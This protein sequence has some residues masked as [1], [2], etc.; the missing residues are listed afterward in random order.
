MGCPFFWGND[1]FLLTCEVIGTGKVKGRDGEG[2]QLSEI[3]YQA[4]LLCSILVSMGYM[5]ELTGLDKEQTAI[6]LQSTENSNLAK[7]SMS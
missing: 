2:R 1:T 5:P 7:R 4:A 6:K 3:I